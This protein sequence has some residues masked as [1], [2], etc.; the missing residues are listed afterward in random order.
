M[1]GTAAGPPHAASRLTVLAMWT[2]AAFAAPLAGVLAMLVGVLALAARLPPER[3]RRWARAVA[4]F[5]PW[6][7]LWGLAA[8]WALGFTARGLMVG[9]GTAAGTWL[10][11]AGAEHLLPGLL[12]GEVYD[13]V[14]QAL[15]GLGP[16]LAEDMALGSAMMVRF[17]P[18][19]RAE[20][21]GLQW[22]W[23]AMHPDPSFRGRV[24]RAAGTVVP[25]LARALARTEELALVLW[26]KRPS[27]PAPPTRWRPADWAWLMAA[28]GW[29]ALMA[30][31]GREGWL[32]PWQ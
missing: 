11:V 23:E 2:A 13:V 29:L 14:Y 1:S 4:R 18:L 28:S 22:G 17:V 32:W 7:L 6:A 10:A 15:A 8:W 12:P 16:R 21:Q 5:G 25:L 20:W 26:L 19:V 31:A 27:A 30:V 3:A 9:A 24:R